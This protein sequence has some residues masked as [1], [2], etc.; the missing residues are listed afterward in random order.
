MRIPDSLLNQIIQNEGTVDGANPPNACGAL[1]LALDLRDARIQ[2]GPRKVHDLSKNTGAEE[3]MREILTRVGEHEPTPD[4]AVYLLVKCA[5]AIAAELAH[6][7]DSG[8]LAVAVAAAIEPGTLYT[9]KAKA[10]AKKTQK[11]RAPRK[12]VH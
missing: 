11:K 4:Y 10:K 1:R 12:G 8:A 5:A 7:G 9:D 6:S 3:F 2:A